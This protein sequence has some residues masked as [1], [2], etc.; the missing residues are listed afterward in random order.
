[1]PIPVLNGETM[2]FYQ[3]IIGPILIIVG[4]LMISQLKH[5]E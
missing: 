5:F 3:P 2:T 1:M 4:T